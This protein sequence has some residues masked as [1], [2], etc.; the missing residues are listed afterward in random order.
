MMGLEQTELMAKKW[1]IVKK[2]N[3]VSWNL[4]S[5]NS[6]KTKDFNPTNQKEV[7]RKNLRAG[8]FAGLN[9][10]VNDVEDV[11][12]RPWEEKN[13]THANQDPGIEVNRWWIYVVNENSSYREQI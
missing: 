11:E 6:N 2:I 1:K 8:I 7:A 10:E 9:Q 3:I 13:N 4:I 12:G 5:Q